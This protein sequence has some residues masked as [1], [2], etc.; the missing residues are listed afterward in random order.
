MLNWSSAETGFEKRV[1]FIKTKV[2]ML[3]TIKRDG[4]KIKKLSLVGESLKR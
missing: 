3:L 2:K 1:L 4:G